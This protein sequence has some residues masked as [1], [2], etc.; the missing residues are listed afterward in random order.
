MASLSITSISALIGVTVLLTPISSFAKRMTHHH[1]THRTDGYSAINRPV[2]LSPTFSNQQLLCLADTIYFEGRSEP[3][4][5]Q[6][7]IGYA[8]VERTKQEGFP[9]TICG[10]VKQ[11]GQFSWYSK[12]RMYRIK[13][14]DA[15]KRALLIARGVRI[16][17][18]PNKYKGATHFHAKSVHPGWKMRY[19]G[20]AGHHKFYYPKNNG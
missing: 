4:S 9:D 1:K 20:M 19:A 12:H 17:V 6:I 11:K 5:G 16:G 10:V 15:W 14:E 8:T 2:E 7:E 3:I 13:D 18:L